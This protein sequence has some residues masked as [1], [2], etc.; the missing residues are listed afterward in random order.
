MECYQ[1]GGR[2]LP[3]YDIHIQI[4]QLIVLRPLSYCY[5]WTG[6]RA[7]AGGEGRELEVVGAGAYITLRQ[8]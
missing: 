6:D 8:T 4:L 2:Q 1:N 3:S 7:G 5:V